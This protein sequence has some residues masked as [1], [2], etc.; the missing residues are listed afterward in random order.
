MSSLMDAVRAASTPGEAPHAEEE[1]GT[2]TLYHDSWP[3]V[4]E[5]NYDEFIRF[6]GYN[7]ENWV[8]EDP[9]K[10]S[11]WQQSKGNDDGT[12]DIIWLY[13]YKGVKFR[14]K[15][16]D[17]ILTEKQIERVLKRVRK[18]DPP[19]RRTLGNGLGA[20]ETFTHHQGDEQTGKSEG[21]GIEG[22]EKRETAAL[23]KSLDYCKKLMKFGVNIE[24]IGDVSSGDRMENIFGHYPSQGRTTDTLRKQYEYATE[25][26]VRRI[27]AFAEFGLPIVLP[28]TPSNHGEIRQAIGM[29]PFTSES[30]NLDLMLAESVKRVLMESAIADQLTWVIPHDDYTTLFDL[31]G[32][33]C[34]LTHGHKVKGRVDTWVE[35][36]Q[37]HLSFHKDYKVKLFFMGHLH[38]YYSEDINGTTV[39]MSPALDG[40]SPWILAS[41]GKFATP[42]LLAMTVSPI[43]PMGFSHLTAL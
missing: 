4:L 20:P 16:E 14:R 43:Y 25:A 38:H 32:V 8:V 17:D 30:D 42:G 5:D 9:G 36:Q 40:G 33:N 39:M 2:L 12:R 3:V 10:M 13:S 11:K 19:I 18:W 22:L 37:A 35:K 15:T 21:G 26:E 24:Q 34:A 6:F 41:S 31:S 28:R 27:K 7:P 1:R 23:E 29:A